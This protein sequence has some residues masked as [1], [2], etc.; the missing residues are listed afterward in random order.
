M[1]IGT[2]RRGRTQEA[3][4]GTAGTARLDRRTKNLTKRLRPGDVFVHE[5]IIGSLFHGRVEAAARVGGMDAIVPSVGGWARLTGYN[6]IFIDSRDPF[7]LGFQ[8]L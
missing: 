1:R 7:A 4:P 5:S 3:G 8:V 6:T 2:L